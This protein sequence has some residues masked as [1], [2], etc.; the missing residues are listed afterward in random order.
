MGKIVGV[1]KQ[2]ENPFVN[3]FDISTIRK[4]G[5]PGHYY[6]ASRAKDVDSLRLSTGKN[7]PDG[8]IIFMLYGKARD[9]IVLVKQYRY[10]VDG[11]VYELP[12]GIMEEGE[13][14]K[15]AAI[16][17]AFEETGLSF[18]PIDADPIFERGYYM[19]TGLCDECCSTIFG[20]A[21]GEPSEAYLEGDEDLSIVL[22][23]RDEARRIL[24]EE[25][26]A[27]SC[28]VPLMHFLVDEDPF[29]FLARKG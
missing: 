1:R 2:T 8:V 25:T 10:S 27:Y 26:V 3:L 18:T 24:T 11:P 23:D 12:A 19:T 28:A 5:K 15:E 13:S 22:A 21:E 20:Y 16:R 17:E 9:R 6:L 7:H 29:A 4:D 14:P